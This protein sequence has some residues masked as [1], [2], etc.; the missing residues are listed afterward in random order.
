MSEDDIPEFSAVLDE[1]C[2]LLSRGTY[3][4]DEANSTQWFRS[5]AAH[6][7]DAVRAA[8]SAHVR[9][10]QRGRFVPSP[11]DILAQIQAAKENDGRPGPEE[12]W[13]IAL[14]SND[15][16]ATVVWTPE[17]AQAKQAAQVLLDIGDEVGARMAFRE[18]YNRIV[19]Q[20]RSAGIPATWQESLGFDLVEREKALRAAAALGRI[21]ALPAPE[22]AQPLLPG[23][24]DEAQSAMDRLAQVWERF[25]A[26]RAA[27]N[28]LQWA[29]DLK[30][31]EQ[32]W[33]EG[34]NVEPL[35]QGQ[36]DAWRNALEGSPQPEGATGFRP[37]DP[38]KLPPGMR[39]KEVR[40]TGAAQLEPPIDA[41]DPAEARV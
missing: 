13:A 41:Y 7:I 10:P 38:A 3:T 1:T 4:P 6:P 32:A 8:F 28:P 35:T 15:E 34:E 37:I 19:E 12:A 22:K 36:R 31:Q 5:L 11:A 40:R 14:R 24:A 9:D 25:N 29:Y 23:V 17:I 21:P 30:A 16:F 2:R 18:A 39:P 20:A 26:A 33:R 27:R